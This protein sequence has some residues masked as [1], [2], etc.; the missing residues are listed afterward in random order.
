M[1]RHSAW[2]AVYMPNT[3]IPLPWDINERERERE[4]R[5][6]RLTLG[7]YISPSTR[8]QLSIKFKYENL[9][10]SYGIWMTTLF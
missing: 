7:T 1:H 2:L 8:V 10:L 9:E 4:S 5:S 3:W 6:G